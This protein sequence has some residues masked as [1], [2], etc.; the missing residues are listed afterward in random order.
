MKAGWILCSHIF[1]SSA[2]A[3]GAMKRGEE[4]TMNQRPFAVCN[5]LSDAGPPIGTRAYAYAI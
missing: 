3:R 5:L 1:S 4:S 2:S